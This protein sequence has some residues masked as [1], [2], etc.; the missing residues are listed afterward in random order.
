MR[1]SHIIA[2]SC[3]DATDADMLRHDD[4]RRKE[5]S[6]RCL[7]V[8]TSAKPQYWKQLLDAGQSQSIIATLTIFSCT[9]DVH[10]FQFCFFSFQIIYILQFYF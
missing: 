2:R 9:S 8:L 7:E 1:Q 5:A 4:I 3:G 10:Y 6:V